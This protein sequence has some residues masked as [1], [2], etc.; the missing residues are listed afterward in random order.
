MLNVIGYLHAEGSR[1]ESE[2]GWPETVDAQKTFL[3][4]LFCTTVE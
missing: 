4:P 1:N 2:S 3:V